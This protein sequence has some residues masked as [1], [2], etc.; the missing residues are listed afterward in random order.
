MCSDRGCAAKNAGV[1]SCLPISSSMLVH[2]DSRLHGSFL[3]C[4]VANGNN[5]MVS[6]DCTGVGDGRW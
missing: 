4:A 5:A 3:I 6:H 2:H 1:D